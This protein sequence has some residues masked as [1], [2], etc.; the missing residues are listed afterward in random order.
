VPVGASP[1][2]KT[3]QDPET[4]RWHQVY[5]HVLGTDPSAD[6]LVY[7]ERDEEFSVSVTKTKSKRFILLESEQ[8]LSSEVRFLDADRPDGN[9]EVFLPREEDHQK[10]PH[11]VEM[12]LDGQRPIHAETKPHVGHVNQVVLEEDDVRPQSGSVSLEI[13]TIDPNEDAREGR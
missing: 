6:Q 9:F 7:E 10:R 13:G 4:L 2:E 12:F 1:A 11:E 3:K 5:R 8:T